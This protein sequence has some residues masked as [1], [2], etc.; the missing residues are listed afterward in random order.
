M[1]LSCIGAM[2]A[3]HH[4][5]AADELVR[6]CRPGGRIALLSWTPEGFVGQL[7]AAM[8]PYLPPPPA[9]VQPPPLWGSEEHVRELLGE[10]VRDL[11]LRRASLPVPHF[12]SPE[13]FR[14]Y[15]RTT[16]GPTVVAYRA[17]AGD[18]AAT[19]AL[20]ADLVALA[21]RCGAGSGDMAWEYLLATAHRA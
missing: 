21:T 17:V 1:V 18:P 2:F 12:R 16:Y 8:R 6:V 7:F 19:A 4:R 20:D 14:D 3:P 11:A 13:H 10:R 5:A 15:F 9:G